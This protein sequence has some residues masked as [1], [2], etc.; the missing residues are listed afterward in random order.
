MNARARGGKADGRGSAEAGGNL[1]GR[2]GQPRQAH[3]L[4]VRLAFWQEEEESDPR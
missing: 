3:G 2:G 1:W 4:Q